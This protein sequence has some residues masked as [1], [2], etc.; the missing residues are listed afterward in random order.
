MDGHEFSTTVSAVSRSAFQSAATE[1]TNIPG[2]PQRPRY[3]QH[4]NLHYW[5]EILPD[6]DA[7]YIKYNRCRNMPEQ[8]MD[9][10]YQQIKDDIIEKDIKRLVLDLRNNG[11]GDSTLLMPMIRWLGQTD[12]FRKKRGLYVIVGRDTFSSALLNVYAIKQRTKAVFIGE[13]TGGKPNSHGEV[14]Y[15]TLK[16]SGLSIRYSTAYYKLIKDDLL[17]S[18]YPDILCEVT[19]A[20]YLAGKDPALSHIENR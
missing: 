11:G 7:L 4:P 15:L 17:D 3:M 6:N 12:S 13:P 5:K 2:V 18:F 9:A 19:M 14:L 10:F 16:H 20:D 1:E 8:P